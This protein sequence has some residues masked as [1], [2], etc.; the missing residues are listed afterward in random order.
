MSSKTISEKVFEEFC[1]SNGIVFERVVAGA[2]P[3]PDYLVRLNTV[4]IYVEVKQI[5]KDTNFSNTFQLREPGT[6]IRAKINQARSQV[7]PAAVSGAPAILLVYNNLDPMQRF[8][9]EPH[10]FLAAMY[11]DLTLVA[12]RETGRSYPGP[13]RAQSTFRLELSARPRRDESSL[14]P[15]QAH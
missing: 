4:D 11:G 10:D 3:T 6:H 1:A 8:G 12:S 7:R 13:G 2:D 14:H 9:T 5:D 15:R